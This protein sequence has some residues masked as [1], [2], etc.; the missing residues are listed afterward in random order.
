[1][2]K[3]QCSDLTQTRHRRVWHSRCVMLANL[4]EHASVTSGIRIENFIYGFNKQEQKQILTIIEKRNLWRSRI[5][6]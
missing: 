2:E 3:R 6:S 4:I 5:N 1:M